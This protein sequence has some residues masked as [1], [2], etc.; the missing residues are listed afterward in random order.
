MTVSNI[1]KAWREVNKLFPYD[2]LKDESSSANTGYPVYR[3]TAANH[4]NNWISDLGNRLE[5]NLED[6]TTTNIWIESGVPQN[7]VSVRVY[8]KSGECRKY[9]TYEDYAK[10]F[11]FFWSSGERSNLKDSAEIHFENII[12]ALREL[13]E[14]G[15]EIESHRDGLTTVFKYEKWG[16]EE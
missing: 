7:D 14:D 9:K 2:Y 6:G 13:D 16:V 10:D 12:K 4:P 11:R 8:A 15:M 3:S 5:V 1:E